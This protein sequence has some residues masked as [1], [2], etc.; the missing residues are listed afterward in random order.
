MLAKE[1]EARRGLE[2]QLWELRDQVNDLRFPATSPWSAPGHA[3]SSPT[4]HISTVSHSD[5]RRAGL[6]LSNANSRGG[7]QTPTR[8]PPPF[9]RLST[10][11][12]STGL[13]AGDHYNYSIEDPITDDHGFADVF[14]TPSEAA[15]EHY[16]F[17]GS[18][19]PRSPASTLVGMV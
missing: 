2:S 10:G 6:P 11:I 14:E 18:G 3:R 4:H 12:G 7:Q 9:P 8:T 16:G 13:Q 1:Q 17:R 15:R 19:S 5:K